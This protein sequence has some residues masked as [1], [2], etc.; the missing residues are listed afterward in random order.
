MF[1]FSAYLT[2]CLAFLIHFIWINPCRLHLLAFVVLSCTIFIWMIGRILF[3]GSLLDTVGNIY[4][5]LLQIAL[6]GGVLATAVNVFVRDHLI[7]ITDLAL[8]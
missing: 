6:N 8:I 4:F 7:D 2:F 3:R 1:L 5:I